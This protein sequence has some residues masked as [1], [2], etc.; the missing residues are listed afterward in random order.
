MLSKQKGIQRP[1][2]DGLHN[3]LLTLDFMNASE[4]KPTA[5]KRRWNMGVK[6]KTKTKTNKQKPKQLN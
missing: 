2:R 3:A 4:Q 5:V 1:P 6:K